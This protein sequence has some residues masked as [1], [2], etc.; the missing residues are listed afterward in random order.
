MSKVGDG[1]IQILTNDATVSSLVGTRVYPVTIPQGKSYPAIVYFIITE[2]PEDTKNSYNDLDISRVQIDC[3]ATDY[4][5]ARSIHDAV[6]LALERNTG[7]HDSIVFDG[8]RKDITRTDF[9]DFLKIFS[10][11]SDYYIRVKN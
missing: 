10:Y 1:I 11:S 6:R 9:D 2:L 7:T 3:M 5:T 4:A 8:V